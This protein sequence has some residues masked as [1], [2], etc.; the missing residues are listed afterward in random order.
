MNKIAGKTEKKNSITQG[1]T[2]ISLFLVTDIHG[3]RCT[4][5]TWYRAYIMEKKL[6]IE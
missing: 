3:F 6:N 1:K 4:F 2:F 5:L